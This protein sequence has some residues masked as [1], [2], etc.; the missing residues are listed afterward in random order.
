MCSFLCLD[1]VFRC[2]DERICTFQFPNIYTLSHFYKA[3][4]LTVFGIVIKFVTNSNT[5][6]TTRIITIKINSASRFAIFIVIVIKF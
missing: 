2:M 1:M 3:F 6:T 5:Y 4:C